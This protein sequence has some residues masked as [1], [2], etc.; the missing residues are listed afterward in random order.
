VHRSAL[1]VL[2]IF[3]AAAA[4]SSHDDSDAI[5][6][7]S[8]DPSLSARLEIAQDDRQLPLPDECGTVKVATQPSVAR[9]SHSEVLTEQASKS[10]ILGNVQEARTMLRRAT[11]LD[12]TNASAVYH[13]GRT[14]EELGDNAAATTAYCRYLTLSPSTAESGETR[15]RVI[16]LSHSVTSVAAGN[17]SDSVT[18]VGNVGRASSARRNG[19]TPQRSATHAQPAHRS[20]ASAGANVAKARSAVAISSSRR[21]H[22]SGAAE[23]SA[24]GSSTSSGP[25][26][27]APAGDGAPEQPAAVNARSTNDVAT[28]RPTP[29]D[30][31]SSTASLPASRGPNRAQSAGIGA[32]TGAILGAVAGGILGTMVGRGRSPIGSGTF[33]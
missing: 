25:A 27:A 15:E 17:V 16:K 9:K 22:S 10:E 26:T 4:C 24:N 5:Q 28:G 20:G 19:S 30:E 7:L 11:E 3:A 1:S 2:V 14:S 32:A 33:H 12:A 8:K 29:R 31:Q 23:S 13:L 21:A 6:L 18:A